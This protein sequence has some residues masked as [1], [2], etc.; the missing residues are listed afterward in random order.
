MWLQLT[1][2]AAVLTC[3]YVCAVG[4]RHTNFQPRHQPCL[5]KWFPVCLQPTRCAPACLSAC[6]SVP[7]VPVQWDWLSILHCLLS[8]TATTAA[9][10]VSFWFWVG[11]V[12]IVG[13]AFRANGGTLMAHA[14]N[15]VLALAHLLLTRLPVVS[16]HF[17]VSAGWSVI[18]SGNG[19][20][21]ASRKGVLGLPSRVL[22]A[23]LVEIHVGF[24]GAGSDSACWHVRLVSYRLTI[25]SGIDTR[26]SAACGVYILPGECWCVCVVCEKGWGCAYSWKG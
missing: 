8:E 11:L 18:L 1:R 25:V 17:Q 12:G 10:F 6:L 13:Q 16:T 14:G 9:F 2:C 5:T 19:L 15:F 3:G 7:A 4:L 26:L 23:Q 20:V 24:V 21:P 22:T